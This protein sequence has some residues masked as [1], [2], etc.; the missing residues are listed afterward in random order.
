MLNKKLNKNLFYISFLF[1]LIF[2]IKFSTGN[3]LAKIYKITKLE[4]SEPYDLNFNKDK[5][6]DI[7]FQR[8]FEKLMLTLTTSEYSYLSKNKDLK[9]IKT[10]VDSFSIIDEKFINK[11]YI[12]KFEVNFSKKEVLNF[13][14]N[15]N[16]FPSIPKKKKLFIMPILIDINNNQ[17]SLFSENP[18]YID[19]NKFYE[20]YYLLEYILPNEDLDDFNLLK[21]NIEN[22][23][24]YNFEEIIS[25]YE[26]NDYIILILFKNEDNIRVLSRIFLNN[27]LVLLNKNFENKD[28]LNDNNLENII[29]D[30]K[31][32]YENNWKKNNIINTSIKLPITISIDSKKYNL[33]RKF[34]KKIENFELVSNFYIE[35]FSNKETIYKII[36]NG[37]PNK[38]IEEFNLEGIKIDLTNNIWKIND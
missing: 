34:E 25:K 28:L 37:T 35:N 31:L 29:K 30:L 17:V 26:L 27:N 3:A 1:F 13:F 10:L 7:A 22:I 16:I 4:I 6:I 20:K 5:I 9:T 19:W 38:F 32:S 12:A 23:E 36:Y 33:I 8:A 11:K 15:K 14:E 18:F 21:K 24:N 2:F